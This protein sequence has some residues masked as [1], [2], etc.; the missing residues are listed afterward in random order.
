VIESDV[1]GAPVTRENI[2]LYLFM[3]CTC[4]GLLFSYCHR[5]LEYIVCVWKRDTRISRH[6]TE[7]VNCVWGLCKSFRRS[8]VHYVFVVSKN[9]VVCIWAWNNTKRY[10]IR[11]HNFNKFL[12]PRTLR[13]EL[14]MQLID[15]DTLCHPVINKRLKAD[16]VLRLDS[17]VKIRF[18]LTILCHVNW[19]YENE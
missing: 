5:M 3:F 17:C 19:D 8:K 13:T 4:T 7:M 16:N 12:S 18:D 1:R 6:Y 15:R 11:I 2:L 9:K 10:I 14:Q